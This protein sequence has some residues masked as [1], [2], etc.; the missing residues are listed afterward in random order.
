MVVS[1][2]AAATL[3]FSYTQEARM[4]DILA[5][6]AIQTL[7]LQNLEIVADFAGQKIVHFTMPRNRG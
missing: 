6:H 1:F 7:W 5:I 2:F 4:V 3:R